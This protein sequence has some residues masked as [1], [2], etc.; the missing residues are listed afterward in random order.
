MDK[1]NENRSITKSTEHETRSA[2]LSSVLAAV[3]LTGL[4]LVVGLASGSL[5]ILAEAAHS[6]LDLAAA[7]ITYFAVRLSGKSADQKHLYGHGKAE[8]LSAFFETLLLLATCVWII[9][10]AFDRLVIKHVEVEAL[11]WAFM[12]MLISI[13]VDVSRS[14]MLYRTAMKHGSQA[15]EADALHFRTD[16]WSSTVVLGGLVGVE[17][18]NT[19]PAL[20]FL[21]KADAVAALGVAIIVI[22]IS[23]SLGIRTVEGLMD[24]AP[25]GMADK[26]KTMVES[27]SKVGDCHSVRVRSSG[28]RIFIDVHLSLDGN[29]T[30]SEAHQITEEVEK[31]VQEAIPGADVTIHPEPIDR[32]VP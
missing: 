8:N 13:V 18:A 31:L 23:V 17:I 3:F 32:P 29:Q 5:G 26:V 24:V 30:L 21:R 25:E 1:H 28:A 10:E 11:G 6:G 27:M 4:K 20:D 2:A 15:L 9:H 14:R 16:I 12:V 22:Y 7:L 19:Y